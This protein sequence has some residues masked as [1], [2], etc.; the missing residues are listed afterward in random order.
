[1]IRLVERSTDRLRNAR[2]MLH[3]IGLELRPRI[4][5]FSR[6]DQSMARLERRNREER[7]TDV[8]L[9]DEMSGQL[10]VDDFRKDARHVFPQTCFE[11]G[12]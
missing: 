8:V 1:L 10:T 12:V 4:D 2:E 5:L 7:D 6:H 9:P 11:P 3:D